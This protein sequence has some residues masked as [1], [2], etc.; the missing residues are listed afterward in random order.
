MTTS[1]TRAMSDLA[2]P[3]GELLEEELEVRGIT[4]EELAVRLGSNTGELEALIQGRRPLT[5]A[6]AVGLEDALP[7]ISKQVWLGLEDNYRATLK[8]NEERKGA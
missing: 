8:R 1:N 7:G 6:I 2:I 3:P 5:E 4:W